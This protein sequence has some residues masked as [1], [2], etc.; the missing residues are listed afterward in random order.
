M[1]Q[2]YGSW[3][4]VDKVI[5]KNKQA[6]FLAHPVGAH[7]VLPEYWSSQHMASVLHLSRNNGMTSSKLQLWGKNRPDLY[8]LNMPKHATLPAHERA[9]P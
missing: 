7:G 9:S 2:K 6:Y 5:A 8:Q 1:C 4:A 3:L